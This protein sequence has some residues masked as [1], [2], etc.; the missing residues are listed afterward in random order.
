VQMPGLSGLDCS[1]N[2]RRNTRLLAPIVC[3]PGETAD[4][5]DE[6]HRLH[7]FLRPGTVPIVSI[8][9]AFRRPTSSTVHPADLPASNR[10]RTTRQAAPL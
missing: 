1:S 4:S 9:F 10:G 5:L 7:S 3:L 2:L 6:L 8:P